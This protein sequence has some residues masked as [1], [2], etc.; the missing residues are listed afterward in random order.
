MA[1]VR[2]L[3]P[4]PGGGEE[5]FALLA[6]LGALVVFALAAYAVLAADRS[7]LA[8]LDAQLTRA[9]LEAAADGAVAT[10]VD[11]LSAAPTQR[12]P[13]GAA[14]RLE[15][16]GVEVEVSVEDE[17]GKVPLAKLTP[18]QA[19]RL[20]EAAGVSGARLDQLVDS[21]MNWQTGSDRGE[22]ARPIDYAGDGIRPRGA[23]MFT[24]GELMAVRGM[25]ETVYA[26]VAPALTVFPGY[27]DAFDE[28]TASPLA[29]QVMADGL[30][31]P[32]GSPR[33]QPARSIDLADAYLGRPFTVRAV[34]RDGRGGVL[35]K[36]VIVELT[37]QAGRPYWVRAID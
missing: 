14:R 27:R 19:R 35:R 30:A 34:A 28:N 6:A 4:A 18:E 20:F 24:L 25:D 1:Q 15:I 9:R 29:R 3:R 37:G 21:V 7:A 16:E 5:G 17:R 23:P 10:A 2:A 11:G 32:A 31:K 22:G 36:A 33:P 8:A 26:R 13:L 12:W